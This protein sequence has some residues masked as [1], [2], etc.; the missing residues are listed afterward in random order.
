MNY[1]V[2]ESMYDYAEVEEL[3]CQFPT[4]TLASN[5]VALNSRTILNAHLIKPRCTWLCS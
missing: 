2:T 1:V 4:Q 5:P 3:H